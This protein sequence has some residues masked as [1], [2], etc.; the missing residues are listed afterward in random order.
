MVLHIQEN[1]NVFLTSFSTNCNTSQFLCDKNIKNCN[2]IEKHI[3][4]CI[5]LGGNNIY[6]KE[7][8]RNVKMVFFFFYRDLERRPYRKEKT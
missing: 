2:Q 1:C 8:E 4:E 6:I 3:L 5:L 7:R